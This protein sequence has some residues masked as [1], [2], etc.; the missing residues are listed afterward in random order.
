VLDPS[1]PQ[2]GGFAPVA[3]IFV[4]L[5]NLRVGSLPSIQMYSAWYD[6]AAP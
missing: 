3:T 2:T 1:K 5:R 6:T 4:L